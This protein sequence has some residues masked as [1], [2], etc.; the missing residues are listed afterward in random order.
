MVF[1]YLKNNKSF[2]DDI[3][4]CMP[5]QAEANN[6]E[7]DERKVNEEEAQNFFEKE[8]AIFNEK[9]PRKNSDISNWSNLYDESEIKNNK[10]DLV[11]ELEIFMKEFK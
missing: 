8:N 3:I 9:R 1:D 6:N 7:N 11:S 2:I 10:G 4:N 5:P